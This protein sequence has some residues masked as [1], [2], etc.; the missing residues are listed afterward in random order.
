[1]RYIGSHQ[2][3]Y[4]DKVSAYRMPDVEEPGAWALPLHAPASLIG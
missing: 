1:M 3:D 4:R 2:A